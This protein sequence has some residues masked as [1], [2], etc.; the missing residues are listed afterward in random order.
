MKTKALLTTFTVGLLSHSAFAADVPQIAEPIDYVAVC[1]EFGAGYFQL[2]GKKT[3]LKFGG[4]VRVQVKTG[5]LAENEADDYGSLA[6]GRL[7]M[8]TKTQAG[9]FEVSTYT[10][11]YYDYNQS[12]KSGAIKADDAFVTVSN[13]MMSLKVGRDSSLYT[14]FTGY[15][16]MALGGASWSDVAP[17]QAVISVPIS[18]FTFSVAAEDASYF[19]NADTVNYAA[20]LEYA[21]SLFDLKLSGAVVDRPDINL[22]TKTSMSELD[23]G[24]WEIKDDSAQIGYA[25]NANIELKPFDK[26]KMS[27]GAQYGKGAS[28]YTGLSGSK[29]NMFG[30]IDTTSDKGQELDI[31][32]T[33]YGKINPDTP[34][35]VSLLDWGGVES[36]SLSGG[37]SW[38]LTDQ[39]TFMLEGAYQTWEV[40]QNIYELQGSDSLV[41]TSLVWMPADGLGIA[42][43]GGISQ[44]EVNGQFNGVTIDNATEKAFIG[45][46]IQYTF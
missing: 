9:S 12:G 6:R 34:A 35:V 45:S 40:K 2:P 32:F 37:L 44:T 21:S 38:G 1:D 15:A 16:W 19:G 3:C 11:V 27:V 14:G 39:F 24:V 23:D 18:N 41:S 8:N 7:W 22:G 46:R 25:V 30:N 31:Y 17:L 33:N 5:N 29:Y 42:L 36:V 20:A 28:A 13:D 43:G 4:Q 26:F 10:G